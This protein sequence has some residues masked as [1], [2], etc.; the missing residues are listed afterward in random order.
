MVRRSTSRPSAVR[1]ACR[2]ARSTWRA[3]SA[4]GRPWATRRCSRIAR[5]A[6]GDGDA[7]AAGPLLDPAEHAIRPV[8]GEAGD[9]VRAR[10]S[11][12]RT[13]SMTARRVTSARP[14]MAWSG[15]VPPRSA[16]RELPGAPGVRGIVPPRSGLTGSSALL[17][18]IPEVPDGS[19]LRDLRQGVDGRLQPAV[20][21]LEPGARASPLPAEPPAVRDH[22]QERVRDER[23]S[24]ARAAGAPR[25]SPPARADPRG[26]T[27]SAGPSRPR[28]A[29]PA[30]AALAFSPLLA[31]VLFA[32]SPSRSSLDRRGVFGFGRYRAML[33][34]IAAPSSVARVGCAGVALALLGSI[35]E[36]GNFLLL[37]GLLLV[38]ISLVLLVWSFVVI[39]RTRPRGR[40]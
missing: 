18:I 25:R 35:P 37:P 23:P 31:L 26:R 4:M 30:L 14:P 38:G 16:R 32:A 8:A 17:S 39:R 12:R 40:G 20:V 6:A 27:S 36:P 22:G 28:S 9:A 33:A 15:T 3:T 7:Q 11:R 13:M 5:V 29:V 34:F 19:F 21:R 1:I 24:S 10:A 2:T